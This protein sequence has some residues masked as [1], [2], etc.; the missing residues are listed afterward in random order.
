M[1][2]GLKGKVALVTGA[3]QGI[4]LATAVGLAKEGCDVAMCARRE[5][6]LMEAVEQVGTLG[7]NVAAIPADVLEPEEARRF[8]LEAAGQLGGI[9]ILINNVG[10]GIGKGLMESSDEDWVETFE[11]N[12]FQGVRLTRLV[13]PH[14]Q[15]RGGGAVVFI[16]SISGWIP[17]LSGAPQYGASKAAQIL[18]PSR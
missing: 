6:V 11:Y 15:A 8:V 5:D 4:G 14:M 3:S 9:D 2:L 1:D 17:Q 7:V 12:V 10:F 18:W 16:S 13:V